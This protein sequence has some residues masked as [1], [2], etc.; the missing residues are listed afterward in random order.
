MSTGGSRVQASWRTGRRCT[1]NITLPLTGGDGVHHGGKVVLP[2][3]VCVCGTELERALWQELDWKNQQIAHRYETVAPLL[4]PR[5]G[6]MR[7]CQLLAAVY[8][9]R[10]ARQELTGP[11]KP[12][13]FVQYDSAG[14]LTC[15]PLLCA[16]SDHAVVRSTCRELPL[17]CPLSCPAPSHSPAKHAAAHELHHVVEARVGRERAALGTQPRHLWSVWNGMKGVDTSLAHVCCNAGDC[18]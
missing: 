15:A 7:L 18:V 2:A 3:S 14:S 6:C 11:P 9:V 13:T 5:R 10:D 4:G 17:P 1:G 8:V 12:S 16:L